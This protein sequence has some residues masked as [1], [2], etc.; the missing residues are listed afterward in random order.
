MYAILSTHLFVNVRHKLIFEKQT[1][2]GKKFLAQLKSLKINRGSLRS[3]GVAEK[4]K[5]VYTSIHFYI[6]NPRVSISIYLTPVGK[7]FY[8]R[9]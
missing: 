1:W 5:N 2:V 6:K 7:I 8:A 4:L 3:L 9:I